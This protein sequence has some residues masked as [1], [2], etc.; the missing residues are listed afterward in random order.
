MITLKKAVNTISGQVY[1]ILRDEI[2]SGTYPAGY[3]LQE[4]EL[5]KQLSVSRSPVREALR[6]LVADRLV[7]EI[8]NKGIFVREFSAKDIE[9]VFD[10][11]VMLESY[12][13]EHIHENLTDAGITE[14]RECLD[15]LHSTHAADDLKSYIG[16]D[17]E[18]HN[19]MIRFSGNALVESI[20][21]QVHI[22]IQQF[23]IYSLKSTKRFDKS[24]EEHENI[25]HCI[26]INDTERAIRLNNEHLTLAKDRIIEYL[27]TLKLTDETTDAK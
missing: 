4:N 13:I 9:E 16:Y 18:L 20:Y 23:R 2:S 12:A 22:I 15:H 1:D 10:V 6:K 8:P 21:N 7:V 25:V 19:I 11:R 17:T 26:L 5:A 27:E 14:F 24:V 3:W